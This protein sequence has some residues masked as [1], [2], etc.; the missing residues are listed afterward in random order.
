MITLSSSGG[1]RKSW[2]RLPNSYWANSGSC[3]TLAKKPSSSEDEESSIT[4]IFPEGPP[5]SNTDEQ[6]RCEEISDGDSGGDGDLDG[7]DGGV[8]GLSDEGLP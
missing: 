7:A 1:L 3:E 8:L 6:G 2:L 5:C 4:G